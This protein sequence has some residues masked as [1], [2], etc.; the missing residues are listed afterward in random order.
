[1]PYMYA[2]LKAAYRVN[3]LPGKRWWNRQQLTNDERQT[4]S[5]KISPLTANC[6]GSVAEKNHCGNNI[7][8]TFIHEPNKRTSSMSN[9]TLK[10]ENC[11]NNGAQKMHSHST[12]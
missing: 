9:K 8:L 10:N 7:G 1:M 5:R 2:Y 11:F 3:N 6:S 4:I 12:R